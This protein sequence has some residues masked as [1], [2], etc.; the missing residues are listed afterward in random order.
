MGVRKRE[1]SEKRKEAKKSQQQATASLSHV[2]TSTRKMRITV[3][4][5][6]GKKVS[7]A[8]AILQNTTRHSG[9]TALLALKS[10]IA[11]FT[12]KNPNLTLSEDQLVVKNVSVD[13]G[14]TVKRI[15]PAPMGRAY[16]IRK[17]SNHLT[18]TVDK[19]RGIAKAQ[20]PVSRKKE[21]PKTA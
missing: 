18:I 9:R 20:K 3:S 19:L 10:A 15:S 7:E 6:R 14:V 5:I 2:P 16:R 21:L 12:A 8:K 1:S 11:N 13:Q 4:M 17:R